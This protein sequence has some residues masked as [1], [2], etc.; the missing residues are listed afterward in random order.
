MMPDGRLDHA[1]HLGC[2]QRLSRRGEYRLKDPFDDNGPSSKQRWTYTG[3]M[4]VVPLFAVDFE[5]LKR[6]RRI[7]IVD[8]IL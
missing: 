8:I 1:C 6:L 2:E 3:F 7:H 5:L 4:S